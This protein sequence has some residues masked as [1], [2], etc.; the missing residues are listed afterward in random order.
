MTNNRLVWSSE[1]G[2]VC[3]ECGNPVS[4]CTCRKK[5][6]E[7]TGKISRDFPDDGI[8]RIIRETKGHRGKTVTIIGN[9]TID[10]NN[11]KELAKQLKNRCG[12]GGTIKDGA[13]I[14]QGD[15]RQTIFEEL[16]R[17]GHRAKI[18]G[19]E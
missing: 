9:I 1:S 2:R 15:H 17:Q 12:T 6:D 8:I 16:T 5:N 3:P 18:S 4:S 11:L 7:K 13:I 14:I 10:I 19:D